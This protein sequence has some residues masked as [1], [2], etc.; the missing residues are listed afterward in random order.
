MQMVFVSDCGTK[1]AS[2]FHDKHPKTDAY[3]VLWEFSV[4]KK[5]IQIGCK[6]FHLFHI[7][8]A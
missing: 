5:F 1:N 2:G 6:R 3:A 7:F 4:C 8:N